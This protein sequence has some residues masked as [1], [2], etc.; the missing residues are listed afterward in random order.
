[1]C[2]PGLYVEY[3]KKQHTAGDMWNV[4]SATF[5]EKVLEINYC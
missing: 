4:L 3:V 1:M 2:I 5:N